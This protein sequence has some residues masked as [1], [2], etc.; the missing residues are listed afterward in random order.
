MPPAIEVCAAVIVRDE[1]YLLARR[2]HHAHQGGKWEFPGGKVH[3]GESL[4]DCIIR[5]LDEELALT[6]S[7]PRLIGTVVH[8]YPEKTVRLHFMAC[9][10]E[11]DAR[12][13][14]RE[15]LEA[16]WFTA[17]EMNLLDIAPADLVFV[18]QRNRLFSGVKIPGREPRPPQPLRET[19]HLSGRSPTGEA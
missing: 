3:A 12:Q 1:R 15:H 8:A 18:K 16:G 17:A 13:Q 2:P 6:V 5:E 19:P 11:P 7:N 4:A 10:L 14:P 9:D